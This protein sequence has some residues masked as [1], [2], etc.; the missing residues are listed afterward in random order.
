MMDRPT[1]LSRFILTPPKKGSG[2]TSDRLLRVDGINLAPVFMLD[3]G[4]ILDRG[5][6][7]N[8]LY[9]MNS[10]FILDRVFILDRHIL[11]DRRSM[12]NRMSI[13]D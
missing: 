13:T 5:F 3:R 8:S 4:T 7:R 9:E 10:R 6:I 1:A 12:M 2:S 11:M